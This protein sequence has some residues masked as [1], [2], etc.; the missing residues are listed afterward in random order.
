MAAL[1]D[2]FFVSPRNNQPDVYKT[3]CWFL[4]C[5][6][7]LHV[8]WHLASDQLLHSYM[9]LYERRLNY[10]QELSS[11]I[12]SVEFLKIV[13]LCVSCTSWL[14][15]VFLTSPWIFQLTTSQISARFVWHRGREEVV[16]KVLNLEGFNW[17]MKKSP[18]L[19]GVLYGIILPSYGGINAH[20][21]PYE[22]TSIQWKVRA[23]FF[24]R[25]WKISS[26]Q[27]SPCP[28]AQLVPF[29]CI[30]DWFFSLIFIFIYFFQS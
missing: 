7:W 6:K 9:R 22:T 18:W 10:F 11:F 5:I 25:G 28:I 27:A 2:I 16:P 30:K 1:R 23:V 3:F 29:Y 12:V 21:D 8:R 14:A 26:G 24:F 17:T 13:E 4:T 20:K 15:F 19:L